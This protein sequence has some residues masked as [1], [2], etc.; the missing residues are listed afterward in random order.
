MLFKKLR[1]NKDA[2]NEINLG[3]VKTKFVKNHCVV[4][5]LTLFITFSLAVIWLS[6]I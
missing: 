3:K 2:Q 5:I 6:Q 4:L 1:N